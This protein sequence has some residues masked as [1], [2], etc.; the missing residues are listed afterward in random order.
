MCS[1]TIS[2]SDGKV[3]NIEKVKE[4]SYDV[5][6]DGLDLK[7]IHEDELLTACLPINTKLWIRADGQNVCV[8]CDGVRCVELVGPP[9]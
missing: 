1:C 8:N 2:F 3:L 5:M 7:V 4:I 6:G 9:F